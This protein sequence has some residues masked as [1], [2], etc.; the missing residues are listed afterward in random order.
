MRAQIFTRH[1]LGG[2][3]GFEVQWPQPIGGAELYVVRL[4]HLLSK[5]NYDVEIIAGGASSWEGNLGYCRVRMLPLPPTAAGGFPLILSRKFSAVEDP[6]ALRIYSEARYAAVRPIDSSHRTIGILHGVEW[7]TPFLAYVFRE[8]RYR[9]RSI[10]GLP[11]AALKFIYFRR[12]VPWLTHRGLR[13]LSAAV[14][15]D[16]NTLAYLSPEVVNRVSVI[17]N[18]VDTDLFRPDVPPQEEPRDDGKH[19]LLVPRNLNVARGVQLIPRVAR[20]MRDIRRDFVFW[21]VGAG[22]LRTYLENEVSRLA[23]QEHVRLLGHVDH[24]RLPAYYTRSSAVLIP[25]I[26]SEGT[27]LAALEGMAAGRT[28]VMTEVGGLREIG[29][30]GL[31]KLTVAPT[32]DAIARKLT[33]VLEDAGLR[34]KIGQSAAAYVRV[35]H[36]RE[37]WENRWARLVAAHE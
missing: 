30:D 25:S 33:L 23:V 12:M 6:T 36:S 35:H 4:A 16:R 9:A 21:I 11:A 24:N 1:L 26:F 22:P 18:F 10:G 29:Q 31:T 5:L 14:S 20:L 17:P 19:V 32:P 34:S 27:S 8:V 2:I 7:D 3:A 13:R 15:V 28:V 37:L